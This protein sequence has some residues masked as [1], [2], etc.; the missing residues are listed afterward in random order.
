MFKAFVLFGLRKN[1]RGFGYLVKK[2]YRR[3]SI[4]VKNKYGAYFYLNPYEKIDNNILR[5]G[6]FDDEV[7][8]VLAENLR[9]GD[10]FWDVG[11]NIGL[12][13]VTIKKNFPTV[14][15]LAFEPYPVNFYR[16]IENIELNKLSIDTY[17]F[18]LHE[19]LDLKKLFSFPNNAGLTGFSEVE[20]SFDTGVSV[21]TFPG[22]FI[23]SNF[24]I[25]RPNLIKID[26]EGNELNILN[27]LRTVFNSEELHTVVFECNNGFDELTAFFKSQNFEVKKL[28]KAP[29]FI[30]KRIMR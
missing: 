24:S 5:F 27:G 23:I 9:D 28:S 14:T 18:A 4:C 20:G 29:N 13:A 6:Y 26:T 10:V 12:H 3:G 11:A 15:C 19:K 8:K 21:P 17:C 1:L 16:L 25:K 22:D 7:Y 30:A 2:L